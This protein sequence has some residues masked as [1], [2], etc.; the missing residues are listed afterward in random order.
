MQEETRYAVI[1]NDALHS[2]WSTIEDA[3]DAYCES[4]CRAC[5]RGML[6]GGLEPFCC[7]VNLL[8]TADLQHDPFDDPDSRESQSEN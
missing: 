5:N 3:C 7:Y 1:V 8:D 4:A 6:T 2:T